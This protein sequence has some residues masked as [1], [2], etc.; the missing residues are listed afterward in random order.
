[1][2]LIDEL[3]PSPR[4]RAWP[5]VRPS[6]CGSGPV[7]Y[8]Q[9]QVL[10]SI[11]IGERRR[12]VDEEAAVAGPGLDQADAGARILGEAGGED[13]ARRSRADDDVVELSRRQAALDRHDPYSP[14]VIF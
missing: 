6:R 5:R 8:P 1:M 9:F 10:L 12:H 14:V 2:P 11:G 4:P 3:P 7:T 13:A